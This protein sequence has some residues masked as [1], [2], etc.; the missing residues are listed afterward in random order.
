MRQR[1][2]RAWLKNETVAKCAAQIA[3]I[4][5]QDGTYA[6]RLNLAYFTRRCAG[7]AHNTNSKRH[8]PP[9]GPLPQ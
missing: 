4:Q 1:L 7:L 8:V 3:G 6:N 5:H 2:G 9:L